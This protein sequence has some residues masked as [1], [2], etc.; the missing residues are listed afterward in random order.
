MEHVNVLISQITKKLA[1]LYLVLLTDQSIC[2]KNQRSCSTESLCLRTCNG[3]N[4][5][6]RNSFNGV[7][8]HTIPQF[9][10]LFHGLQSKF[11]LSVL[12]S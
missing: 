1:L 6:V 4:K 2:Q 7:S 11:E 8:E 5:E 10:L 12:S 9:S 3:Y